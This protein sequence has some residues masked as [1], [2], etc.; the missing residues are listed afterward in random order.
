M[1]R[2]IFSL[3]LIGLFFLPQA[4][5]AHAMAPAPPKGGIEEYE[6]TPKYDV[7]DD[8]ILLK[9]DSN[10]SSNLGGVQ[11][12]F[13]YNIKKWPNGLIP[14]DFSKSIYEDPNAEDY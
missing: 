9:K 14:V 6:N 1:Q 3:V 4:Q 5:T 11:S 8:M 10:T 13:K 7:M 12:A 2:S